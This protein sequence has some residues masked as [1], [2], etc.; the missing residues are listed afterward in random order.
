MD[1]GE[2]EV[3]F[4]V[5]K[6]YLKFCQWFICMERHSRNFRYLVKGFLPGK[7]S[8]NLAGGSFTSTGCG[9]SGSLENSREEEALLIK[10][11]LDFVLRS[12]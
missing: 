4:R 1:F 10:G 3:I 7:N 9:G 11:L 8:L 6:N 2:W 12:E 5:N